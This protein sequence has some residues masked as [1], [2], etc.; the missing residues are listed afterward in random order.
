MKCWKNPEETKRYFFMTE[1]IM[2][3]FS[4]VEIE[5]RPFEIVLCA[6]NFIHC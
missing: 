3:I 4:F 5:S 2:K 6:I 1:M